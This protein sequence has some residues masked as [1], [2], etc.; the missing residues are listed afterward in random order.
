MQASFRK[1]TEKKQ[2]SKLHSIQEELK[3]NKQRN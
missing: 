1:Y 2:N 3:T